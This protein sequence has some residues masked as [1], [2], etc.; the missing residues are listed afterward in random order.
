MSTLCKGLIP[1]VSATDCSTLRAA[2]GQETY[3]AVV[4]A[5][6]WTF[7]VLAQDAAGNEASKSLAVQWTVALQ[8]GLLYARIISG[9]NG[10]SANETAA[11]DL[12]VVQSAGFQE[13]LLVAAQCL[14]WLYAVSCRACSLISSYKAKFSVSEERPWH[15]AGAAAG[16]RR[17]AVYQRW[18]K[19]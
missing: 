2:R 13:C 1:S 9:P 11:F 17:P 8:P 18:D 3:I 16:Q 19:P 10:P 6:G 15:P 12:Q 5:G 7:E 14:T 4:W